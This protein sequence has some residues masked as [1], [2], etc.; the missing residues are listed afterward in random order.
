MTPASTV[1]N[2]VFIGWPVCFSLLMLCT[3]L[4][5]MNM[6]ISGR[7]LPVQYKLVLKLVQAVTRYMC[8]CACV[9]L[10]DALT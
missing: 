9:C 7:T 5:M 4:I 6:P 2:V 8:M 10:L 3:N 1:L